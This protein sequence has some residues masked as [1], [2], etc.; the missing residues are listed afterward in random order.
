[1]EAIARSRTYDLTFLTAADFPWV[2]DGSRAS[3]A[4]RD[5]MQRRFEEELATRPELVVELRGSVAQR[6]ATAVAA[7]DRHLGLRPPVLIS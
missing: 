6:L 3:P 7:I 4:A 5:R 1:V 2:D